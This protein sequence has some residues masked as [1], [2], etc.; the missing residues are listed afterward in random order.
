M[1]GASYLTGIGWVGAGRSSRLKSLLR[2][3]ERAA[4]R[5]WRECEEAEVAAFRTWHFSEVPL[6][7]AEV[8]AWRRF[9]GGRGLGARGGMGRLGP[10]PRFI[11]SACQRRVQDARRLAL[12]ESLD[13]TTLD[14]LIADAADG[15]E[16]AEKRIEGIQQRAS[17]FLGATGLTTS[18]ILVNSGLLFGNDPLRP[19]GVLVTVAVLLTVA[20]LT[21]VAAGVTALDATTVSFDRALPNSPPQIEARLEMDCR[22]ARRDLLAALLLAIRR[23]E[24]IGDWKLH[25]LG[26]ARSAFSASVLCVVIASVVVLGTVVLGNGDSGAGS[27]SQGAAAIHRESAR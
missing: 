12:S 21:L 17:L 1:D 7:E 10:A 24:M 23:A 9:R 11:D 20:A 18:L 15:Y 16:R 5:G 22:E 8:G 25:Q 2:D 13:V 26:N 19:F 3:R 14:S 4:A 27:T 6:L